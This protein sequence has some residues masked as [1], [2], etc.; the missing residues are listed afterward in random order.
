MIISIADMRTFL[1]KCA[2]VAILLRTWR[3]V[4][5]ELHAA[6]AEAGSS[7]LEVVVEAYGRN[8]YPI[9]L[10][11]CV[12]SWTARVIISYANGLCMKVHAGRVTMFSSQSTPRRL[13]W[14]GYFKPTA[15]AARAPDV[16]RHIPGTLNTLAD[17]LSRH[18]MTS[19][20]SHPS[21]LKLAKEVEPPPCP[22]AWYLSW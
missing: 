8:R 19:V 5:R 18:F 17:A 22:S 16:L 11:G 14:E 6:I 10:L 20:W 2:C 7:C 13:A 3:P 1:G 9:L 4:L 21:E 15:T 12:L